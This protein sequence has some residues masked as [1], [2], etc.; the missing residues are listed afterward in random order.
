[1]SNAD[2]TLDDLNRKF[3]T[4]VD[5]LETIVRGKGLTLSQYGVNPEWIKIPDRGINQF[6]PINGNL[7][8]MTFSVVIVKYNK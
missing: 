8:R 5:S 6:S 1:M 4:F 2:L 3:Q 7:K